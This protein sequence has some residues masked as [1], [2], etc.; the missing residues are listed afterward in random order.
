VEAGFAVDA[1]DDP[2]V[3]TAEN[4]KQYQALV[5][6][7]SNNQAFATQAQRDA[8]KAY[9]E[10]GG[11]LV[12]IH[13]ATGSERDWPYFWGVMGGKFARHP[14]LQKFVVRVKDASNPATKELPASF[15][16]EDEC[17]FNEHLNPNIRPLLVTD[18]GKLV[19]NDRAKY[20]WYLVGD[21]MPLAW[22]LRV[23]PARVFYTALGHTQAH[24]SNPILYQ[25]I[26]GGIL[27]VME[28]DAK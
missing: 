8:F 18:P 6:S 27:W 4:L 22:T 13:S 9:I 11:G 1:S 20:P 19:D 2:A 12:G 24:Y 16:W 5:F 10:G 23:G 21:S 14:P 28:K 25:Q 17:Y 26:L 15:E 7:N 3:F